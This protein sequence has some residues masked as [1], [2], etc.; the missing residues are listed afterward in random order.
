MSKDISPQ[1]LKGFPICKN[2]TVGWLR[3][4]AVTGSM[5]LHTLV[6]ADAS[7]RHAIHPAFA[8]GV[9]ILRLPGIS[10]RVSFMLFEGVGVILLFEARHTKRTQC[11]T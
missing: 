3:H 4:C 7:A 6:S 1:K 8:A 9:A 2:G 5:L 11:V 10:F